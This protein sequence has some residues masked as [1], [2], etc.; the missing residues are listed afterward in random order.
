MKRRDL[1]DLLA[2]HADRG[3]A[4]ASGGGPGMLSPELA[5]LVSLASSLKEAL[6]PVTAGSFEARLREE[7]LSQPARGVMLGGAADGNGP[8]AWLVLAGLASALGIAGLVF[9]FARRLRLRS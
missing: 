8:A 7:L 2:L 6:V 3:E 1:V 5:S 9:F 4:S